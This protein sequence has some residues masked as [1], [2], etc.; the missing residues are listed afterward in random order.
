MHNPQNKPTVDAMK[1]QRHQQ[2]IKDVI[3]YKNIGMKK[4]SIL[5]SIMAQRG[6]KIREARACYKE[7]T[8]K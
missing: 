2:A 4:D 1:A 8:K 5:R 6:I 7:A 3:D